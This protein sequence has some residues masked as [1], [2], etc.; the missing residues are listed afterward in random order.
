MSRTSRDSQ[1]STTTWV[2]WLRIM[3]VVFLLYT[4]AYFDRVNIGMA[5]PS[6]S[7]DLGLS[8]SQSGL[9]A[10]VFFWGYLISFLAAG[11]LAPR[12]GAKRL[13]FWSLLGWGLFAMLSGLA[14]T[15]EQLAAMRFMLGLCEGPVWTSLSLLLSQWFLRAERGRA[16]GLWNLSLP[17]GA[18]LS[19]PISGVVLTY[20][21]WHVMLMLEGLPAWVWA[22]VWWRAIPRGIAQASWLAPEDRDYLEKRL[23]SEQAEFASVRASSD[24]RGM[25][26]QPA[27]W[28]LLVAFSLI[29]MVN[30]G[31]TLWLPSALKAISTAD[32][33]HIGLLSALPYLASIAGIVCV[34]WSSDRFRE[35]R[36]HAGL[37]LL[38]VGVLLYL[39]SRAGAHSVTVEVAAFTLIG[40]FMFMTLPLISALTT[41][42]LPQE[43]AIPAIAFTG[44]IGNLF[45]GFVGPVMVGRLEEI[46]GSFSLAFAVLGVLGIVGGLSIL[47]VRRSP[48]AHRAQPDAG[49][50]PA[51]SA[52]RQAGG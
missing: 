37:P 1:A 43:W 38:C 22:A 9:A 5:L 12:L 27:V 16:F 2:R 14:R 51:S 35:R 30:Y 44:G 4:I 7:K 46:G 24:W 21:N 8:P 17:F 29:N 33:G 23:A 6:L 10:G 34:S 50:S 32:I 25:F 49:P 15:F 18:L 3:P 45:G 52:Q 28:L 31:F 41:D 36:F 20:T 47:A 26:R 48:A 39:G 13:I 19:G 11:F 40:F 42:I